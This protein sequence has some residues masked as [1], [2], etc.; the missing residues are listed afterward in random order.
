MACVLDLALN[1]HGSKYS[2]THRN[3]SFIMTDIGPRISSEPRAAAV[4]PECT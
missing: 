2:R 3:D 1:Q 4:N